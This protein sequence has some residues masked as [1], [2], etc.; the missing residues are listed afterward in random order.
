[1]MSVEIT[2]AM[3]GAKEPEVVKALI[4]QAV[5]QFTAA[6]ETPPRLVANAKTIV[7][8]GPEGS[9]SISSLDRVRFPFGVF[10]LSVKSGQQDG[11]VVL[12]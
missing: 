6:K 4:E 2:I 7:R 9:E 10:D 1:M 11:L 8:L 5:A 12:A 3:R